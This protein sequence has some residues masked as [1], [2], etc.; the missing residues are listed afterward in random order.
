MARIQKLKTTEGM[1]IETLKPGDDVHRAIGDL[2]RF[3]RSYPNGKPHD[4]EPRETTPKFK[5]PTPG[6]DS[7]RGSY[8]LGRN[9]PVTPA[10]DEQS[11]QFHD[12][13]TSDHVD[14]REAW[15]RGMGNQSPH[16][17]FDSGPSGSRYSRK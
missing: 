12:D 3:G 11:P 5:A 14:T 16:P 15:C 6:R 13:K 1:P 10:P 7:E 4:Y 17:K 8:A 9:S 2:Y